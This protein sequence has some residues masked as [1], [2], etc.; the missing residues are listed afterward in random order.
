MLNISHNRV[1]KEIR[2][3]RFSTLER[4]EKKRSG[5]VFRRLIFSVLGITLVILFLPW[6]QNIRSHGK[7]TT[8]LPEQ[9]PQHLNSII[10]GKIENWYVR[11][12][13]FVKKGDT[14]LKISEI[15][16]AYFDPQLLQRTDQQIDLKNAS[17]KAYDEKIKT[18]SDQQQSLRQLRDAAI[19]QMN[20]ELQQTRLKVQ[21][22]SISYEAAKI[23]LKTA[24][25]RFRRLDSLYQAGL[26]SLTD[27]ESRNLKLQETRAKE[28]EARNKWLNSQNDLEKLR[29]KQA[30]LRQKFDADY[31]KIQ[32]E[33]MN[34]LTN[35]L[36]AE[37]DINKLENQYANYLFRQG[38]YFITAPQ[39]G[40]ITQT[41]SAGIGEILKEGSKILTIVPKNY[42]LAV[43]MFVEP[44]DLPLVHPGN[45]VRIQ[46]DGWP[47]IVFSGWPNA[48]HGTFGGKVYAID[49]HISTNGKYRVLI[50]ADPS[51]PTWPEALRVG[52]GTSNMLLLKDVP[53]WYELW[54]KINGFPPEYYTGNNSQKAQDEK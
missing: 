23:Q 18:Q 2:E 7:V 16:D 24:E 49:R 22:D 38:L 32:S 5:R 52:A 48:S 46:F 10:A 39:D 26:K 28:M 14:V 44:I 33:K 20:I 30:Q 54:R 9:R 34:S 45:E 37:T 27:F 15:K 53:I 6:T 12:G 31:A 21:N 41:I 50:Q 4:L 11:E 17:V 1:S 42:E 47:A 3:K 51:Q 36:T 19:S 8:L 25:Y 35:R 40:Y 29:L 13:D 43:E